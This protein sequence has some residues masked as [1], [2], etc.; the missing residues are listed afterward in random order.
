M[1]NF[2]VVRLVRSVCLCFAAICAA[3]LLSVADAAIISKGFTGEINFAES[4]NPLG[5][6]VGD[7]VSGSA[8]YEE[9]AVPA[10]GSFVLSV[11]SNPAYHLAVILGN[12]TFLEMQDTGFGT[13]LPQ[14]FFDNGRLAGLDF[15]VP[16]AE[17][18]F[19]SLTF[20]VFGRVFD[21]IDNNGGA[22]LVT[23]LFNLPS[24]P[25]PEPFTFALLGIGLAGL[26]VGVRSP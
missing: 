17:V 19:P 13:G 9:T 12:Q 25:I 23:G 3:L 14:L 16:F 7:G 15:V 11:D 22:L 8:T 1:I 6:A 26:F 2:Q 18:G 21:V 4:G 24:Q 5:V 10:T 20:E